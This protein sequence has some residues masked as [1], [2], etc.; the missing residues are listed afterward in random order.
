[1]N[2]KQLLN[3]LQTELKNFESVKDQLLNEY[4]TCE[5][6]WDFDTVNTKKSKVNSIC[7]IVDHLQNMI[8][9]IEMMD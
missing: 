4:F 5:S 6:N 2:N 7:E 8:T 9:N 1:M 3:K